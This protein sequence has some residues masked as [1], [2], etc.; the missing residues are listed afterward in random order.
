[1]AGDDDELIQFRLSS[2]AYTTGGQLDEFLEVWGRKMLRMEIEPLEGNPLQIDA[3]LRALPDFAMSSGPRSP[4]RTR[5][6]KEL[7][8]NDDL[9]LIVVAQGTGELNQHGRVATIGSG[10]AVLMANGAP[11]SFI[12]PTP[13]RTIAYRFNRNLLRPYISNLDDLVARPIAAESQAL[14]LLVGYADILNDQDALATADLRR[15]VARHMHDLVALLLGGSEEPRLA[16]LRAARLKTV[17]DDVLRRVAQRGLSVGEIARSQQI[18]ERYIR[19]LFAAEGTSF[20]DFVRDARLTHAYRRLTDPSQLQHP[21]NLIAY[22]SGFG[23][24]SYFN[25][26]FRQRYNMTPS[27]ARVIARP[28]GARP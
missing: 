11:A 18:S 17:K 6:T 27:D 2:A 28:S 22:E 13:T 4:M 12:M 23:D 20:T 8:D 19:Q 7:V 9:I 16:G 5:H 25:R 26:A 1:M 24:L 3:V 14:R 21:I 15:S 10:E